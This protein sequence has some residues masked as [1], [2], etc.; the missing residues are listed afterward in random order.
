MCDEMIMK[1]IYE[2]I[3]KGNIIGNEGAMMI[4]E[5]LKRNRSLTRLGLFSDEKEEKE[6]R[7]NNKEIKKREREKG[8]CGVK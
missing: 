6:I 3:K 5:A 1:M 2:F 4:S 8:M 7:I